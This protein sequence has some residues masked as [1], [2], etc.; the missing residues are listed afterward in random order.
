M[1]TDPDYAAAYAESEAFDC[2]REEEY[3]RKQAE[4]EIFENFF[5]DYRISFDGYE[6]NDEST[7]TIYEI[8]ADIPF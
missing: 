5:E 3:F 7:E 6:E 2:W 8:D 4:E 1:D